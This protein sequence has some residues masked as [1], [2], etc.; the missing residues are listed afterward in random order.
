MLSA[1]G[2]KRADL[3]LPVYPAVFV[4]TGLG[5]TYLFHPRPG[6]A[7]R[8]VCA[9]L[10]LVLALLP[11]ATPWLMNQ[12][13]TA[14]YW[15]FCVGSTAAGLAVLRLA[16]KGSALVLAPLL[17]G[18]IIF[19]GLHHYGLANRY[20]LG[21]YARLASFLQPV[22]TAAAR[23][24]VRAWR[25]HPLFSYELGIHIPD[26]IPLTSTRPKWVIIESEHE[27]EVREVL[28]LPLTMEA[29]LTSLKYGRTKVGLYRV[30]E[31]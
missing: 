26:R 27:E 6:R 11:L 21:S 1:V 30:G 13:P 12:P 17:A 29:E 3:I 23:G 18:L 10:G 4:L 31:E 16:R 22:K 15:L 7:A 14:L 28:G 5:L 19:H 9:V 2:V 25:V 8:I 20:P 24:E